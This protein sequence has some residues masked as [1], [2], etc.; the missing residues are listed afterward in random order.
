MTT[1]P[2]DGQREVIYDS[3][4]VSWERV[5][6]GD[7]KAWIQQIRVADRWLYLVIDEEGHNYRE[8]TNDDDCYGIIEKAFPIAMLV[9]KKR[10]GAIEL[11]HV[12]SMLT[13]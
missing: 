13:I 7:S 10:S 8:C 1:V 12:T 5:R 2:S 6:A 3:P 4:R 11:A 9:G